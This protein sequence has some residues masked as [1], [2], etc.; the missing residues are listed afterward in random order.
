MSSLKICANSLDALLA[1]GFLGQGWDARY[2]A[3]GIRISGLMGP[4]ALPLPLSGHS[5][6]PKRRILPDLSESQTPKPKPREPPPRPKEKG[7][8]EPV[9]V[10]PSS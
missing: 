7:S 9:K 6:R 4:C 3:Y 8:Y 2:A 5:P 1:C 10:V